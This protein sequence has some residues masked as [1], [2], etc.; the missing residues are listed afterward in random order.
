MI[1]LNNVSKRYGSLLAVDDVAFSVKAGEYFGPPRTQ[2]RGKDHDRQDA[3][4]FHA[5]DIGKPVAERASE[6][7]CGLPKGSRLC[8]REPPH[9][10][11]PFRVAV[12]A[13][14]R[15]IAGYSTPSDAKDEC[16]R[17]VGLIGME[18][19]E[20][21]KAGTYSKGMVQRFALGAALMGRPRLL[22][23]DEP[24]SGL[25]PIGIREI[26]LLLESLKT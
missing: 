7:R 10:A 9:P 18:G 24:V 22:I 15:G 2:R 26:R 14:V 21:T 19:R 11:V 25:D 23:L 1:E 6:H 13:A 4:R 8:G 17:I 12:P 3:P 20:H 16:R 5:A